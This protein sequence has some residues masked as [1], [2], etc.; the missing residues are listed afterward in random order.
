DQVQ[1]ETPGE[2]YLDYLPMTYGKSDTASGL[3]ARLLAHT[4]DQLAGLEAQIDSIASL[5]AAD[6]APTGTLDW[7]AAW[8]AFELPQSLNAAERRR[9]LPKIVALQDRRGTPASLVSLIELHTGVRPSLHEAF[10]DRRIWM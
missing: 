5:F 2:H 7:L 9:L 3:L 4:Q 6:F 10:R 8:M 1:L